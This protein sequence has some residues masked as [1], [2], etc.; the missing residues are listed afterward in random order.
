MGPGSELRAKLESLNDSDLTVLCVD[1]ESNLLSGFV[2]TLACLSACGQPVAW[3]AW[4]CGHRPKAEHSSPGRLTVKLSGANHFIPKHLPPTPRPVLARDTLKNLGDN[5]AKSGLDTEDTNHSPPPHGVVPSQLAAKDALMNKLNDPSDSSLATTHES[6]LRLIQLQEQTAALH[7]TFLDNQRHSQELF[8]RLIS[9]ETGSTPAQ[10]LIAPVTQNLGRP[11]AQGTAWNMQPSAPSL[12]P[13]LE[14]VPGGSNASPTL[15]HPV[16]PSPKF[17]PSPTLDRDTVPAAFA[18]TKHRGVETIPPATSS[19]PT[20]VASESPPL[21][22]VASVATES[23]VFAALRAVIAEKTGYPLEMLEADHDLENDL[24]IDSI[25]RVEI[26]ADLAAIIPAAKDLGPEQSAALRTIAAIAAALEQPSAATEEADAVRE[27]QDQRE[28]PSNS[29]TAAKA[30][31]SLLSIVTQVVADK[32]GYPVEMLQQDLELEGDLGIDSIKRVEIFSGISEIRPDLRAP[33]AEALTRVRTI[34]DV[35]AAFSSEASQAPADPASTDAIFAAKPGAHEPTAKEPLQSPAKEP[36]LLSRIAV[37]TASWPLAWERPSIDLGPQPKVALM[38]QGPRIEA[39]TNMLQDLG[40][41]VLPIHADALEPLPLTLDGLIIAAPEQPLGAAATEAWLLRALQAMRLARPALRAAAASGNAICITITWNNG[42]FGLKGLGETANPYAA[43]LHGM[44]KTAAQEWTEVLAKAIDVTLDLDPATAAARLA[45]ECLTQGPLEIGLAKDHLITPQLTHAPLGEAGA[46]PLTAEDRI[47]ITGGARGITGGIARALARQTKAHFI[48][49]GTTALNPEEDFTRD[50]HDGP[51]IKRVLREHRPT[52]RPSQLDAAACRILAAREVQATLA[53]MSAAGA[54]AEYHSCDLRDATAV[55]TVMSQVLEG[56]PVTALIHG[57]GVLQDRLIEDKTD[58]Q[59]LSVYGTKVRGLDHLLTNLDKEGLK[60]LALFSSSS[61]RYGRKGQVDYAAAN[62]VLNKLAQA[63]ASQWPTTRVLALNWGPWNG[64]MVSPGLARLF[65]EEGVGL[66]P[67]EDGAQYFLQEL[68]APQGPIELVVLAGASQEFTKPASAAA[69]SSRAPRDESSVPE[70][71][72]TLSDLTQTPAV[73][74]EEAAV[75]ALPQAEKLAQADSPALDAAVFDSHVTLA[76]YAV[77]S[78][79]VI[80]GNP[81]V[82]AALVMEWLAHGALK[83]NPGL[84]F[85]GL[86]D[87]RV[88]K[89]IVLDSAAGVGISVTANKAIQE[90]SFLTCDVL[91]YATFAD[92]RTYRC[93]GTRAFLCDLLPRDPSPTL[94]LNLNPHGRSSREIYELLF[95]GHHL[96]G[97]VTASRPSELG[98][99]AVVKSGH[100][101][102]RWLKAPYRGHWLL[103]PMV[104][105]GAFQLLTLWSYEALG[106]YSLP[107]GFGS[108]VQYRSSFPKEELVIRASITQVGGPRVT[109][110]VEFIDCHERLIARIDGYECIMEERLSEAF[111]RRTILDGLDL[112]RG[113]QD[114]SS[115][116]ES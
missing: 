48:L 42:A 2:N 50:L 105:D 13:S 80:D 100:S 29:L 21:T 12:A 108:Y 74:G 35:A 22:G 106:S 70:A 102:R 86:S 7:K 23:K 64:G 31:S 78:S 16:S 45:H 84:A 30:Q 44:L 115:S 34:A 1:P 101:P 66:I 54:T 67:L 83:A 37:G 104:I 89:G 96:Q 41:H 110:T 25:K 8:A 107:C 15:P 60:L 92:G 71:E 61:G 6:L 90:G 77:L 53:A 91:L 85:H 51:T 81:V 87:F 19:V 33:E 98:F 103:D 82:P 112:R 113:A 10:D 95:H 88:L 72:P 59:F 3:D 63:H 40:I 24:G 32:T 109:A 36:F 55:G 52:D 26:F 39:L 46:F 28:L 114:F 49:L 56:G 43:G 75:A 116:I 4:D 27:H 65:T 38:G 57:A 93:A 79:H 76:S 18:V 17:R 5:T 47:L 58:E 11:E 73:V 20:P 68:A 9:R 69:A 62:E 111:K 99:E 97:L 14:W 94:T